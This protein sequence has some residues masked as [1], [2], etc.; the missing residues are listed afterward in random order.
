MNS[1]QRHDPIIIWTEVV[2]PMLISAVASIEQG[3]RQFYC[4][5]GVYLNHVVKHISGCQTCDL[6]QKIACNYMNF[7]NE[8]LK[9]R[10]SE[11]DDFFN[12]VN[13]LEKMFAWTGLIKEDGDVS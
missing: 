2:S 4:D 3:F 6:E 8:E 13:S 7:L 5:L 9:E 11:Y 10:F 12:A 1:Q